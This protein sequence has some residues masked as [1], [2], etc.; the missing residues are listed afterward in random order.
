M[1]KYIP[2]RYYVDGQPVD[3]RAR[4]SKFSRDGFAKCVAEELR[5]GPDTSQKPCFAI[6]HSGAWWGYEF[7]N[8][9]TLRLRLPDEAAASMWLMHRSMRDG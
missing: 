4:K 6:R 1:G 8:P 7:G 3:I 9:P 2:V 5:H